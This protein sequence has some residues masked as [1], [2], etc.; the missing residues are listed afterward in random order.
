MRNIKL[1][2]APEHSNENE[3]TNKVSILNVVK[4]N[5]IQRDDEVQAMKTKIYKLEEDNKEVKAMKTRIYKLE[6]DN[7]N[8]LQRFEESLINTNNKM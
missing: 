8:L 2:G 1:N 6:E 4:Q 5:Q 7:K 3:R